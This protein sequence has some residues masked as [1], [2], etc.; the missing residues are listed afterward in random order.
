MTFFNKIRE[1]FDENILGGKACK[2]IYMAPSF[3]ETQD[4]WG[5]EFGFFAVFLN[6]GEKPKKRKKKT[7]KKIRN[8][9]LLVS[10]FEK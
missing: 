10:I 4:I 1:E 9:P 3:I 2:T 8:K 5:N 7:G 6:R